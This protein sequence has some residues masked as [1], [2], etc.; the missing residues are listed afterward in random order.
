MIFSVVVPFLT[1]F[2][3]AFEPEGGA[4]TVRYDER[5]VIFAGG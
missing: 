3:L 4:P 5:N 1:T 2:T